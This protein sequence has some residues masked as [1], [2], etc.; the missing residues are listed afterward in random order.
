ML[1]TGVINIFTIYAVAIR[2]ISR[3]S[4]LPP[5]GA[6]VTTGADGQSGKR[7]RF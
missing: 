2:R 1:L 4:I 5:S 6:D 7:R 3:I